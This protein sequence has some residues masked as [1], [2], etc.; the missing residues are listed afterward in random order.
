[1]KKIK[2]KVKGIE[3]CVVFMDT[4]NKELDEVY[5]E[6]CRQELRDQLKWEV[7]EGTKSYNDITEFSKGYSKI[8][9][10]VTEV[11][12]IWKMANNLM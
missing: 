9:R 2:P 3:K 6:K 7:K 5:A 8:K 4:E 10:N 1:M 12:M 11:V